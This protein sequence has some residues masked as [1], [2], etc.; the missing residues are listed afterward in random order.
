MSKFNKGDVVR[1]ISKDNHRKLVCSSWYDNYN[2]GDLF[3]IDQSESN[4]PFCKPVKEP[5]VTQWAR[6]PFDESDLE[7]VRR[8]QFDYG[9][10]KVE[11]RGSTF[12]TAG[13]NQTL[14]TDSP[15]F[16]NG[17]IGHY[18]GIQTFKSNNLNNS[19]IMQTP[20]T[21]KYYQ[22]LKDMPA[23]E[24]GAIVVESYATSGYSPINDIWNKIDGHNPNI[25]ADSVE[26]CPEW[27]QR[28]YP[29]NGSDT[30]FI[31]AA[32]Y[33]KQF[34]VVPVTKAK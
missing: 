20:S 15:A 27:F 3:T 19:N 9:D 6:P 31:T 29:K 12:V 2:I 24:E 7:L 25:A 11:L 1:L 22:L 30:E 23:L 10:E 4:C 16:K 5:E 8:V 13:S 18:D 21:K 34:K 28:V 14:T 33:K 32:D 26:K 17:Y